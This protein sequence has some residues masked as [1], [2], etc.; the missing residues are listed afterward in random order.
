MKRISIKQITETKLLLDMTILSC[1]FLI[2]LH[3]AGY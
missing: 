3:D 1:L 2:A